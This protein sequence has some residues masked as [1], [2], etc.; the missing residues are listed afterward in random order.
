ME[1]KTNQPGRQPNASAQDATSYEQD[2]ARNQR[3]T[4]Q[5]QSSV[6]AS[7]RQQDQSSSRQQQPQGSSQQQ[8]QGSAQSMLNNFTSSLSNVQ[9]PQ[10]VKDMG[11][12]VAR[13]FN[14]LTTTQ[15]V[16]GGAAIAL[17]ASYW[18]ASS[19]GWIGQGKTGRKSKSS[20]RGTQHS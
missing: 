8:P 11:S 7:S 13:S 6:N 18:A 9:V 19:Q 10:A 3:S 14:S 12:N 2:S 16:I 1:N 4:N 5:S 15:K 20:T 17:G